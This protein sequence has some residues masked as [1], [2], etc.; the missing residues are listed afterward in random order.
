MKAEQRQ[1]TLNYLWE[2]PE[3][4]V[5]LYTRCNLFKAWMITAGLYWLVILAPKSLPIIGR[6]L[7]SELSRR[8]FEFVMILIMTI[9]F[10]T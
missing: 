6:E 3:V 8:R 2:V 7:L 4:H 5:N 10:K 1:I 9:K